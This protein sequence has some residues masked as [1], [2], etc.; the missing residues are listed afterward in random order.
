MT[1]SAIVIS[2]LQT[3]KTNTHQNKTMMKSAAMTD[4]PFHEW[5]VYSMQ[6]CLKAFCPQNFKIG[7]QSSQTL[8][9]KFFKNC[10]VKNRESM[11]NC[12][13]LKETKTTR[14]KIQYVTLD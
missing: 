9:P 13:R 4:S 1:N 11:R 2:H 6:Y 14:N 10:V 3:R 8:L 7:G 12:Y 5:F